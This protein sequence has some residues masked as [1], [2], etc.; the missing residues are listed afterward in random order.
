[1]NKLLKWVKKHYRTIDEIVYCGMIFWFVPAMLSVASLNRSS[2]LTYNPLLAYVLILIW[3][4]H[5]LLGV[6]FDDDRLWR[7]LQ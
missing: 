5:I 6:V 2:N 7:W 4:I 1:M 3:V